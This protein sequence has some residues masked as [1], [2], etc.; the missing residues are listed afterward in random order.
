MT[1][2]YRS[3]SDLN[4]TIIINSARIPR[5]I[6]MIVGIPRSGLLA[7]NILA[8][9]LNLPLSDLDGFLDG[10]ILSMGRT[11]KLQ[12]HKR[13]LS[14]IHKVFVLDDSLC[15]GTQMEAVH[16]KIRNSNVKQQIQY[17]VVYV[18]PGSEK[19]V[20]IAF[21]V[22]PLPRIFEWNFIHNDVLQNSCVDID[23]VI[24]RDPTEAE[25]DDG[26]RYI[27]F[28]ETCSPLFIPTLPVGY[29]VTCRLEKYRKQTEQWLENHGVKYNKLIMMNFPDKR[30]RLE[31]GSHGEFKAKVYREAGTELFI[32][33]SLRQAVEIADKSGK[34]VLCIEIGELIYPTFANMNKYAIKKLPWYLKKRKNHALS[35]IGRLLSKIINS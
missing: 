9:H 4:R 28:I 20:D 3:L 18:V 30:A 1:M 8:L 26:E 14:D 17:G 21:E 22:C 7:A 13:R 27:K 15:S 32:E 35:K 10:R 6:D 12:K 23:G 31:A 2:N 16:Q 34:P 11:R 5:D 29:L 25:N 33:S 19:K 24:C